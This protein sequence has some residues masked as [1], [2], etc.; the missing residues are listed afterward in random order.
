MKLVIPEELASTPLFEELLNIINQANELGISSEDWVPTR[1]Y[2]VTSFKNLLDITTI[3]L[4]QNE[5]NYIYTIICCQK[6][7]IKLLDLIAKYTTIKIEPDYTYEN[8]NLELTIEKIESTQTYMIYQLII[9]SLKHLLWVVTLN[10]LINQVIQIIQAQIT[11][12]VNNMIPQAV[13][14]QTAGYVINLS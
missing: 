5:I 7:M 11:Q 6:G 12:E 9:D 2:A 8:G 1:D 10:L 3:G 13:G 14:S 4:D